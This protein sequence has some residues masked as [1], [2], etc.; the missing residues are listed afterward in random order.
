[1]LKS[2]L[3]NVGT[4]VDGLIK[5]TGKQLTVAQQNLHTPF[6]SLLVSVAR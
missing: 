5:Y 3:L 4:M 2:F 1:M 6:T